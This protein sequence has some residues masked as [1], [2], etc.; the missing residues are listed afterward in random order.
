M[1]FSCFEATAFEMVLLA[2]PMHRRLEV[3]SVGFVAFCEVVLG[4]L[5]CFM[6]PLLIV[7]SKWH[8]KLISQSKFN[9]SD[10]LNIS[11]SYSINCIV[12][13]EYLL[14]SDHFAV[15]NIHLLWPTY[16]RP[17]RSR[18]WVIYHDFIQSNFWEK[19][20]TIDAKY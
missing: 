17:G 13:W 7:I 20:L 18:C 12:L 10:R 1:I 3:F 19:S 4:P 14:E 6:V 8:F 9:Y 2:V 5:C 16:G 15:F 11:F